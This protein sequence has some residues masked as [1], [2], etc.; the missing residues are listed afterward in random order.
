MVMKWI[1]GN[2]CKNKRV[3]CRQS[4]SIAL[5]VLIF[6][7]ALITLSL[8]NPLVAQSQ[9]QQDPPTLEEQKLLQLH[10][11]WQSAQNSPDYYI[12]MEE[13]NKYIVHYMRD[14]CK[15]SL[16]GQ[17]IFQNQGSI[18]TI[19][20]DDKNQVFQGHLTRVVNMGCIPQGNRLFKAY[21]TNQIMIGLPQTIDITWL[22]QMKECKSWI[23]TGTET[24]CDPKTKKP[25]TP[26]PLVL[27]LG[28]DRLIYQVEKEAFY[29]NRLR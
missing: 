24:S 28:G 8:D 26:S 11:G 16:S 3:I 14:G 27:T 2:Q 6:L 4:G 21:F 22:R 1:K 29:L 18:V 15:K 5:K 7:A 10:W 12:K 20:Y 17:W 13:F 19:T 23:F 25:T 9:Y